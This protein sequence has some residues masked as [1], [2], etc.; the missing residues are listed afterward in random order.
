VC[1]SMMI[2]GVSSVRIGSEDT[3]FLWNITSP[4]CRPC[5]SPTIGD[6]RQIEAWGAVLLENVLGKEE[7]F[8]AVLLKFDHGKLTPVKLLEGKERTGF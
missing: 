7:R 3:R 5:M 2:A 6:K 1:T 4:A 8:D